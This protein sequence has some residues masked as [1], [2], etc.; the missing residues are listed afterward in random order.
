MHDRLTGLTS[1]MM[2]LAA[3]GC[4]DPFSSGPEP[5]GGAGGTGAATTSTAQGGAAG[6][7]ASSATGGAAAA[8]GLGQGGNGEGGL[9]TGGSGSGACGPHWVIGPPAP[10]IGVDFPVMFADDVGWTD[11]SLGATG[12]GSPVSAMPVGSCTIDP[13]LHCWYT[14]LA[15]DAAG[16]WTLSVNGCQSGDNGNLCEPRSFCT[17]VVAP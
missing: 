3:S 17:V 12:P 6:S 11:V 8:G 7:G 14:L 5:S 13:F 10:A 4:G 9:G 16:M 15:V 1:V 2:L